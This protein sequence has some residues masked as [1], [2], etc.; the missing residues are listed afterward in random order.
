MPFSQ[1]WHLY[2][3]TDNTRQNKSKKL[4]LLKATDIKISVSLFLPLYIICQIFQPIT[5]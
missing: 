2:S 5:F 3:N 4:N 1:I